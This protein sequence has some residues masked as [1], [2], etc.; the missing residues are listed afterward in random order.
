MHIQFMPAGAAR[1]PATISRGKLFILSDAFNTWLLAIACVVLAPLLIGCGDSGAISRDEYS[2]WGGMSEQEWKAQYQKRQAEEARQEGENKKILAQKQKAKSKPPPPTAAKTAGKGPASPASLTIKDQDENSAPVPAETNTTLPE[3][4]QTWNEDQLLQARLETQPKFAS[5]I[6]WWAKQHAGKEAEAQLILRLLAPADVIAATSTLPKR[7]SAK[8]IKLSKSQIEILVDAL[9]ANGTDVA[10]D[11]LRQI[12]A[13]T[14]PVEDDRMT[15]AA[16][17]KTLCAYAQATNEK[18]LFLVLAAPEEIRAEGVGKITGQ[19]LQ[20]QALALAKSGASPGLRARLA[21][22]AGETSKSRESRDL[23]FPLLLE[24]RAENL[25]AQTILYQSGALTAEQQSALEKY[26]IRLSGEALLTQCG[27]KASVSD[28]GRRSLADAMVGR[29]LW[30]PAFVTALDQRLALDNP[31]KE[32][33]TSALLAC[34]IPA[35]TIRARLCRMI[36]RHWE[37]GPGRAAAAGAGDDED[38]GGANV[39]F[40][41]EPGFIMVLKEARRKDRVSFSRTEQSLNTRDWLANASLAPDHAAKMRAGDVAGEKWLA[42][43]ELMIVQWCQRL[44]IAGMEHNR[45]GDRA[46]QGDSAGAGEGNPIEILHPQ[47]EK[48]VDF[49]REVR[50]AD[51]PQSAR[52]LRV[53]YLRSEERSRPKRL[54][55]Y[56]QN[57]LKNPEIYRIKEGLWLECFQE[58]AGRLCSTD[59]LIRRPNPASARRYEEEQELTVEILRLEAPDFTT[60]SS[61][62]ENISLRKTAEKGL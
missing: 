2:R 19:E 61:A 17:L 48:V 54:V 8:Q 23:L 62:S 41:T 10:Q 16:A 3:D 51:D 47:A 32:A 6:Q 45:D 57:T 7:P 5:A 44:R 42:L 38:S 25:E 52:L 26:F 31:G 29:V 11:G 28:P 13:G 39:K 27:V 22:F 9:G 21:R 49:A 18:L 12:L 14:L 46:R 56:Y 15:V 40:L 36:I 4:Y 50:N 43:E 35:A 58:S 60:T 33:Q 53:D 24:P 1:P 37:E 34:T 30:S 59:V 55:A 20:R